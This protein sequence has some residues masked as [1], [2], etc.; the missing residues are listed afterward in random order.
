VYRGLRPPER[1]R[2]RFIWPPGLPTQTQDRSWG[3]D[4]PNEIPRTKIDPIPREILFGTAGGLVVDGHDMAN[5]LPDKIPVLGLE[6]VAIQMAPLTLAKLD[7]KNGTDHRPIRPMDSTSVLLQPPDDTF[8][9]SKSPRHHPGR[10]RPGRR[11][12]IA[13]G[14]AIL[15]FERGAARALGAPSG[16]PHWVF[17]S[18]RICVTAAILIHFCKPRHIWA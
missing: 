10:D 5:E 18:A 6:Q 8:L 7:A 9:G 4:P 12:A 13:G 15:V 11:T 14:F 1:E 3:S 16:R 2:R 17:T